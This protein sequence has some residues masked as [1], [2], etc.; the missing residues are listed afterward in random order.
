MAHPR[1]ESN[2][3]IEDR[4][5]FWVRKEGV[6]KDHSDFAPVILEVDQL[7]EHLRKPDNLEKMFRIRAIQYSSLF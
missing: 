3:L 1:G 5:V 2:P 7:L 4:I 6:L